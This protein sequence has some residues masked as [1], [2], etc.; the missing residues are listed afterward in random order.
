MISLCFHMLENELGE[1][2]TI[3]SWDPYH[4]KHDD[5]SRVDQ[6]FLAL[7]D[8]SI[9]N[10]N[11]RLHRVEETHANADLATYVEWF[12]HH[13]RLL[14]YNP[15][16][17][18]S[19]YVPMAPSHLVMIR[20]LQHL[21]QHGLQWTLDPVHH[22][23]ITY[24]TQ[25]IVGIFDQAD[26]VLEGPSFS[27]VEYVDPPA[28]PGRGGRGRAYGCGYGHGRGG[29]VP[30]QRGG[31]GR[32]RLPVQPEPQIHSIVDP[33]SYPAA[34]VEHI[35]DISTT[36]IQSFD[37]SPYTPAC[38]SM[39]QPHHFSTYITPSWVDEEVRQSYDD[40]HY[41]DM[42][43]PLRLSF[44]STEF[45]DMSS[46]DL[47]GTSSSIPVGAPKVSVDS[48]PH[49]EAEEMGEKVLFINR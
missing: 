39:P 41:R 46:Q 6:N 28:G 32:G 43:T 11:N 9:D 15:S 30:L 42:T 24:I 3:Q 10:W 45:G 29:V 37:P 5:R 16:R 25:Y 18:A 26:Q 38:S 27:D 44:G 19:S 20:V 2:D 8:N 35:P 23:C 21:Y 40:M 7:V 14:L 47:L 17:R 33:E 36:Q 49:A 12:H 1:F 31:Q 13:G 48:L 22:A 34:E 4:Y